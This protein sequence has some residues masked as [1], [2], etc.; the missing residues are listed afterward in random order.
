MEG[1]QSPLRICCDVVLG[2]YFGRP[3]RL[4]DSWEVRPRESVR[5]S[6]RF[7]AVSLGF[8]MVWE[9]PGR[10]FWRLLRGKPPKNFPNPAKNIADFRQILPGPTNTAQEPSGHPKRFSGESLSRFSHT[11]TKQT[12]PK[13]TQDIPKHCQGKVPSQDQKARAGVLDP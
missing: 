5:M 9:T 7:L 4:V 1:S 8:G 10:C 3:G 6:G 13:T 11:L 12:L 2:R